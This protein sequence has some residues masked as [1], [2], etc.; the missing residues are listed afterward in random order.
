MRERYSETRLKTIYLK[1]LETNTKID[2]LKN[3]YTVSWRNKLKLTSFDFR[4]E[5]NIAALKSY[6]ILKKIPSFTVFAR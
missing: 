3:Q 6:R 1:T 4:T 5:N 2:I